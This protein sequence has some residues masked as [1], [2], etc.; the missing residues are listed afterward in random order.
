[1]ARDYSKE[2]KASRTPERRRAN[3]MRKRA[4]RL[5]IKEKGEAAL[6]GKEVDHVNMNPTDNRR[7]NLS[8]KS[9]SANRKKQPSTK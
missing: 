2:Y 3:I 5:M 1:M 8:I 4:R 7:S 9:K 6:K